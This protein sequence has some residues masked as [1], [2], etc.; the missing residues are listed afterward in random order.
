MHNAANTSIIITYT[1]CN[2]PSSKSEEVL[3]RVG[4]IEYVV[5][6]SLFLTDGGSKQKQINQGAVGSGV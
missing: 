1:A 6:K 5:F 3:W 2:F 4:S